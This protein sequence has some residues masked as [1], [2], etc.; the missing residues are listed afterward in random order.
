MQI[1]MV[2][3]VGANLPGVEV[4]LARVWPSAGFLRPGTH[5]DVFTPEGERMVRRS[6]RFDEWTASVGEPLWP[7]D[8]EWAVGGNLH[9]AAFRVDHWESLK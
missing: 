2:E 7:C 3:V 1:A 8:Y 9:T 6:I 4:S 5:V